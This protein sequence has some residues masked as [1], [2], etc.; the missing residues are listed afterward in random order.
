MY[1]PDGLCHY[2]Y[3]THI[4]IAGP[5]LRST[6]SI[7]SYRT[8][9]N[10]VKKYQTTRG[11]LAFDHRYVT[12]AKI[13]DSA[14][15]S[16][17]TDL[18]NENIPHAGVL[19]LIARKDK[20]AALMSNVKG[21]LEALK[22]VQGNDENK[23]TIIAIGLFGYNEPQAW[24]MYKN[25]I[26]QATDYKAD[27]VIAISSTIVLDTSSECKAAPPD[28]LEANDKNFPDFVRT[29]ADSR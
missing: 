10:V 23:K 12:A 8:F 17:L 19:N 21:V 6:E 18:A 11:G 26:K 3:Y 2:L 9:K 4:F 16:Q 27:T 25:W 7:H 13:K 15:Q 20:M 29:Y 22:E 14:I 24:E 1:P 5:E 28:A